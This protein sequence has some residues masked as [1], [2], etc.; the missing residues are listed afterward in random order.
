MTKRLTIEQMW[1]LI[2]RLRALAPHRPLTYGE[3]LKVAQVQAARLRLWIGADDPA[4]NLIWLIKQRS[5]PVNFLPSYKLGEESGM[6]TDHIG[7]KL[8]V[9]INDNEPRIR[10]RFSIAHELKHV[11]DFDDAERLHAKLGTGNRKMQGQMIEWIANEFAGH[12]LMP[13]VLV[14]RYWF[15]MKPQDVS[16]MA[17]MFDVSAEAM[18]TRLEILGLIGRRKATPRVYFRNRGM[19]PTANL[20]PSA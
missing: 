16:L 14:K 7:G 9:F 20:C 15:S 2:E 3:S 4:I 10:Q 18:T 13:T 19:M 12:L 5:V 8:Q 6:T 1:T 17:S 11:L